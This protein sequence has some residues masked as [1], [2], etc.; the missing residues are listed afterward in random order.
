MVIGANE[1]GVE[2]LGFEIDV[3]DWRPPLDLGPQRTGPRTRCHGDEPVDPASDERLDQ[4]VLSRLLAVGAPGQHER[5]MLASD[6]LDPTQDRGEERVGD[7]D[8]N[9][10]NGSG[11]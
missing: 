2:K 11:P 4:L 6:L 10:P 8:E 9:K 3:H 5:D 7:V 1:V